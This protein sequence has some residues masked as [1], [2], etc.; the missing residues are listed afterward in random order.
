MIFTP[1]P[2]FVG[3]IPPPPL[4]RKKSPPRVLPIASLPPRPASPGDE[5]QHSRRH[6][7]RELDDGQ[8][9]GQDR[10]RRRC[11][12]QAPRPRTRLYATLRGGDAPAGHTTARPEPR[13]AP[14]GTLRA[15]PGRV[16]HGEGWPRV[17][18]RA[19]RYRAVSSLETRRHGCR[20]AFSGSPPIRRPVAGWHRPPGTGI[21]PARP[22]E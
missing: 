17:P 14:H 1:F 22:S 19:A 2:R 5:R 9:D 11:R 21:L 7:R 15:L 20:P 12:N 6:V 8:H 3:P 10:F 18:R 4:A 16:Q 13:P